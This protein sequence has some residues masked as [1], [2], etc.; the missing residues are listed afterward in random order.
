SITPP[1]PTVSPETGWDPPRPL[2]NGPVPPRFPIDKAFPA[3]LGLIRDFV[4]GTA[5]EL[6]VPLDLPAM[7]LLPVVGVS[8]AKNLEIE[9]RPGWREVPAMYT[10]P[11][12]E[13]GECKSATFARML[14][15]VLDWERAEAE[16][17]GPAVAQAQ[18]ERRIKE[19]ELAQ[20]RKEA[21]K[22]KA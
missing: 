22:G 5:E 17:L 12:L 2:W 4:L 11:L 19:A 9:P 20:A 1:P 13:S 21:A 6:Q 16:K 3:T 8:I 14:Q 15:P 18:E 7:L 10:L